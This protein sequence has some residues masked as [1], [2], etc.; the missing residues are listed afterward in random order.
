MFA[1]PEKKDFDELEE[2]DGDGVVVSA[3]AEAEEDKFS[4]EEEAIGAVR[5]KVLLETRLAL[6]LRRGTK[7]KG[8]V[9]CG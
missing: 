9:G 3:S 6:V 8:K 4:R 7:K 5:I 2:D 1:M